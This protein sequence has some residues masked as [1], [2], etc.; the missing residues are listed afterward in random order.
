MDAEETEAQIQI[1][2]NKVEDDMDSIVGAF[3]LHPGAS[4][5]QRGWNTLTHTIIA[6]DIYEGYA[7]F[8]A[9]SAEGSMLFVDSFRYIPNDHENDDCAIYLA[10]SK[11]YEEN[12]TDFCVTYNF[13]DSF[14]DSFSG[15]G[16]CTNLPSVGNWTL[17]NY[18]T[19]SVELPH[20][21]STSFISPSTIMSCTS[22]FTFPM[23]SGGIFEVNVYM[24]AN[25]PSNELLIF[26]NEV[27]EG[28]ADTQVALIPL[29]PNLPIYQEGWNTLTAIL[30][31]NGTYDGYVTLMAVAAEGSEVL[32]DS[33]RYIPPSYETE[34]CEIY[35][36]VTEPDETRPSENTTENPDND[37]NT[38]TENLSNETTESNATEENNTNQTED[39][40]NTE[41]SGDTCV[42]YD[43]EE[44][45]EEI[46]SYSRM[47][48]NTPA[49]GEW[50]LGNYSL[51][52]IELPHP[53]SH[54]F[55]SPGTIMSCT[56]SFTFLMSNGGTFE[57][58]V[59]MDTTEA[60]NQLLTFVNEVVEGGDDRS[61]ATIPLNSNLPN[62]EKGWNTLTANLSGTGTYLGYVTFMGAA[63]GESVILV[64]SF[65]YIPPEYD[66][67]ACV[68]YS[69]GSETDEIK[70]STTTETILELTTKS[71]LN[72]TEENNSNKTEES[73]TGTAETEVTNAPDEN[74]TDVTT[75]EN[76]LNVTEESN[77]NAT[78]KTEEVTEPEEGV[79]I[80]IE[81]TNKTTEDAGGE[82]TT[83]LPEANPVQRSNFWN[84]YTIA[85]VV[86]LSVIALAL[87]NLCFYECE[88]S[89]FLNVNE[90]SRIE[91]LVRDN[92]A[93]FI[94]YVYGKSN[95][96]FEQGWHTITLSIDKETTAHVT[97]LGVSQYDDDVIVKSIKYND[98]QNLKSSWTQKLGDVKII[99]LL[100]HKKKENKQQMNN[101]IKEDLTTIE[102]I[103]LLASFD[104]N[105]GDVSPTVE[106]TGLGD[107]GITGGSTDA[108][109]VENTESG[110]ENVT[111]GST[112]VPTAENTGPGEEGI[113]GGSTDA[114][115]AENTGPGEEGITGESTDAPT[116]E[117]TGPGEEGIT[118][119]STDAPT[120]ENTGPGEEGITGESTDAPTAENTGP[121][122]EGITGGSTDAPT[123]E[124]TGP[125]EE[126]V[127]G[128]STDAITAENT[129]PG[130]E[131][132]TGGSTNA[133]TAENTGPGE[134]GITGGSTNA[135]TAENTGT[136]EEG[137]TG[138][139]TD[140]PTAENTGPGEEGITGGS[141]NA[142][143]AENTESGGE[144]V[145]GGSTNAPTAENT[146][147][148]EEG[149]TGGTTDA[150]T[151]EATASGDGESATEGTTSETTNS[152]EGASVSD[153]STV[154]STDSSTGGPV[155]GEVTTE[156]PTNAPSTENNNSS[157]WNVWTIALVAVGS[158]C[159]VAM[160]VVGA[161]H[162]GR[163]SRGIRTTAIDLS[164]FE[165]PRIIPRAKTAMPPYQRFGGGGSDYGYGS[166]RD[167]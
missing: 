3:S 17:G 26:V 6:T 46:F 10:E 69:Q 106:N 139:S 58:N 136:S 134:E 94:N 156:G 79:T 160:V 70:S 4:N 95:I 33:F 150:P 81:D 161:Y 155:P 99:D 74:K 113:T 126:G 152:G 121:G 57:V 49:A 101:D 90:D 92:D 12:S 132:I 25:E 19:T 142:P 111:G 2:V 62:Y 109:T 159:F 89:V 68:I 100:S 114:P 108:L 7:T 127:T 8:I 77:S 47:C 48:T 124:N 84:P 102:H 59:Y 125:G 112:N 137:I 40:S 166:Q 64:D 140:A 41:D 130:E 120:A 122:E 36:V 141:T 71:D 38:T 56:S 129:G 164:D 98:Y 123:A 27:V 37:K 85:M 93:S 149:V 28:G 11:P 29:T 82:S 91:V 35:S 34:N 133:P 128:E 138:G 14:Y 115:T 22:S 23:R 118:G 163:N 50:T 154:D 144:N 105:E 13:E 151:S 117:N 75:E 119:E 15:V 42:T 44:N 158:G 83:E 53:D 80:D 76:E 30:G 51:T 5:Y 73:T 107:E 131:G 78:D 145:T 143:T 21:D 31:G 103:S 110:G 135:P 104:D 52:S 167:L 157:F 18:S 55:I 9:T 67:E 165:A 43:F 87:V 148:S 60:S 153:A 1:F 24:D 63:T 147:T 45:F 97:L 20:P 54:Y 116:A 32:V 72:S 88:L 65:R 61:V 39:G 146:G 16:M 66:I 96:D 86:A 162:L